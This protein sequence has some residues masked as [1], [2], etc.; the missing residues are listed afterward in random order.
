MIQDTIPS[1]SAQGY[2]GR[3]GAWYDLAEH[4]EGRAKDRALDLLRLEPGLRVLNA[5]VGT[6]IDQHRIVRIAGPEGVV[7]GLDLAPEMLRLTRRRT[8]APVVRGDVHELP[9]E[10][11]SFDRLLCA[12]VL[13]LIPATHLPPVLGEL[14]RVLHPSGLMV[15]VSLTEGI[16]RSSRALMGA[17]K[18]LYRR[19]PLWLG[20]CRPLRLA[21]LVAD[22]GLQVGVCETLVQ[23]EIPSEIVTAS[24]AGVVERSTR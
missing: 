21:A 20:G 6:G 24:P 17:W 12:Y 18:W 2:Y 8:G 4:F 1:D 11:S 16:D 14:A 5:G 19:Q 7:V 3:L 15:L 10:D 22:A 23:L 13:D 9:F